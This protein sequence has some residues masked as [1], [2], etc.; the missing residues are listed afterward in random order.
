MSRKATMVL[1]VVSLR[2]ES[3]ARSSV[4]P[5]SSSLVIV[6]P[7]SNFS[8]TFG[9]F[10]DPHPVLA[11]LVT[12]PDGETLALGVGIGGTSGRSGRQR[13]ASRKAPG[14]SGGVKADRSGPGDLL[15]DLGPWLDFPDDL[16]FFAEGDCRERAGRH[17]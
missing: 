1:M 16:R 14:L 10:L 7:K 5:A 11:P 3:L 15:D 6:L 17:V 2:S 4:R 12:M 13:T 8:T 9:G